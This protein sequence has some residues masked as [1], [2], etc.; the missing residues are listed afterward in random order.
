VKP[1]IKVIIF[2]M[3][4]PSSKHR[5]SWKTKKCGDPLPS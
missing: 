4:W 1:K 2:F 3:V 5:F